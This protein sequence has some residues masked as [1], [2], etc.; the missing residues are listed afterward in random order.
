MVKM[1]Q[2]SHEQAL[3]RMHAFLLHSLIAE[4]KA[5]EGEDISAVVNG[6]KFLIVAPVRVKQQP[7]LE[8]RLSDN[9][10]NRIATAFVFPQSCASY[11]GHFLKEEGVEQFY[12]G[13]HLGWHHSVGLSSVERYLVDQLGNPAYYFD[14]QKNAIMEMRFKKYPETHVALRLNLRPPIEQDGDYEL[15]EHGRKLKAQYGEG[16]MEKMDSTKTR[17]YRELR[18]IEDER[19]RVRDKVSPEVVANSDYTLRAYKAK[20]VLLAEIVRCEL[21]LRLL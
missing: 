11:D 14:L 3:Q 1:P 8:K 9:T 16:Y 19:E 13:D 2:I 12:V 17:R 4:Q 18:R 7:A 20:G 6:Q 21:Q 10:Q 15:L 5:D